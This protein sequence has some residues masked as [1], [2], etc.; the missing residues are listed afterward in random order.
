M[1]AAAFYKLFKAVGYAVLFLLLIGIV[2]A[3]YITISHWHG[4][5]V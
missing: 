2:Y 3:G 5:G 1:R 4:I